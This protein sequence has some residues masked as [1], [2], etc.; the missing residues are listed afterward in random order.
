M[1]KTSLAARTEIDHD[2]N[3]FERHCRGR[4]AAHEGPFFT[5][6]VENLFDIYLTNLPRASRQHYNC[7]CCRRFINTYGSLA[8][9]GESGTVESVLWRVS[10]YV[11]AFFINAAGAMATE[12][13]K[14][15][16]TGVFEYADE[17]WG[18]PLTGE[19]T[20]LHG[21][22]NH[23][24][25][26]GVLTA[27]QKMAER[28][29]EFGMLL[30]AL[31]EIKPDLAAEAVRV[32][33]SE[34]LDRSEKALGMAI[35]FSDL[36]TQMRSIS[37]K[38]RESLIWRAV[39]LAPPGFAHIRS[40]MLKTLFDDLL[41][42]LSFESVRTRWSSKMDPMKYQ[43]PQAPP[44]QGT[45]NQ[46]E[47]VFEKLGLASALQRRFARVEEIVKIWEPTCAFSAKPTAGLGTFAHLSP[48]AKQPEQRKLILPSRKMTWVKFQRDVLPG[49]NTLEL[50]VP[51]GR[52]GFFGLLTAVDPE[53]KP[54]L[55]W[56]GLEGWMR[57]PFSWYFHRDGSLAS[58]WQLQAGQW[59][60][61]TAISARP[62]HWQKPE[63]FKRYSEAAC[64]VLEGAQDFRLGGSN[65]FPETLRSE[66]HGVRSVIEAYS[67]SG[68]VAGAKEGTANGICFDKSSPD[69]S[70]RVRVN[71]EEEFEL[72]RWE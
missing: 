34:T 23:Q 5:T 35:W 21:K 39:A 32:L 8:S 53:A 65:I 59:C 10:P 36:Q 64:F 45:I 31:D 29:E 48:K 57:N 30:R 63:M 44:S 58:S 50:K 17:T 67:N 71:G 11:P 7:H 16:I 62:C 14:A 66:L 33:S 37:G 28:K 6:D 56:D 3:T 13:R 69:A 24:C 55:Q 47:K 40:T 15:K 20:H 2:Y 49:A 68:S 27:S 54:L 72:D 25:N 41:A 12:V 52:R 4:I 70:F 51:E 61:V 22:P 38:R 26:L 43:R 1:L 18:T 46:A 60:K 9:I 19:W 42:G